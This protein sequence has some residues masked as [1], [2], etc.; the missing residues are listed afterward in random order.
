MNDMIVLGIDGMS[1]IAHRITSRAIV[2]N[3][4]DVLTALSGRFMKKP[5]ESVT[6]SRSMKL[7]PMLSIWK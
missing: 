7:Y 4:E 5:D 6:K 1:T 3:G 2:K